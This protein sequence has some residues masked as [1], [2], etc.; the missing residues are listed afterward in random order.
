MFSLTAAG[1]APLLNENMFE[2][3]SKAWPREVALNNVRLMT[4]TR[5]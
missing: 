4:I 2:N 1:M 5:T 3:M